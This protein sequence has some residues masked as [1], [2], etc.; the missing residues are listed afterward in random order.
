MT[1]YGIVLMTRLAES[2]RGSVHNAREMAEQTQ[3][4]HPVA[5]K[6]LKSLA[7]EGLLVSQRGA[8]GGYGLARAPEEISV[9]ELI[10]VLEGP[11]GLTECSAHPGQCAQEPA[12]H[13]REPWQRINRVVRDA[14]ARVT[15]ADLARP[16]RSGPALLLGPFPLAPTPRR[17]PPLP[18][19]APQEPIGRREPGAPE[20]RE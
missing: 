16:G 6:L 10:A 2:E 19:A 3:V 20:R 8:R 15:L 17:E 11:I 9:A 1:D 14:L 4:P 18:G 13:V 5:S 12:C 7:R